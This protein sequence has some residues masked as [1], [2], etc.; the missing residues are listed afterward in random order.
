MVCYQKTNGIAHD[1][2]FV[3]EDYSLQ[4]GEYLMVADPLPTQEALSDPAAWAAHITPAPKKS[5]SDGD[6]AA[7]LVA[8]QILT[9]QDV[10]P[11]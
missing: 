3:P 5:L 8:K 6:L 9:L 4:A 2:R 11:K 1:I 10:T 7:V